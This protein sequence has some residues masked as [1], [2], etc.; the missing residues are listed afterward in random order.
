MGLGE[1]E[2]GVGAWLSLILNLHNVRAKW[3]V[4]RH[5]ATLGV[6]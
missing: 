4:R 2:V 5:L 1:G 6:S 3:A